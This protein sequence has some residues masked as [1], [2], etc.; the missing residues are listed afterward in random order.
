MIWR[1]FRGGIKPKEFKEATAT[2]PIVT[3]PLPPRVILP[4]Q[5]HLGERANPVVVRD[6][7]V[8][9][10]QII[11][12]SAAFISAPV[13]ASISGTVTRVTAEVIEIARRNREG[14]RELSTGKWENLDK[15]PA[16]AI[17]CIARK[18]GIV[19]LGGATFPTAVKL[20]PPAGCWV[21]TLIINGCECEPYLTA[22][23]R[24]MVEQS[25]EIV[26]GAYA[27]AQAL[28]AVRIIFAVE[29]NKPD[30]AKKLAEALTAAQ[31]RPYG[32]IIRN[33]T[34]EVR[35]VPSRYPQG[36]E[37]QLI[38]SLTGRVVPL[39]GLP[40]QVGVLVHNVATA[41]ALAEAIRKA[42]PLI[43]RVVTVTGPI[44]NAPGNYLVRLGTPIRELL[45][46][47][48]G[49]KEP[50]KAIILGG[51]MMGEAQVDDG[52]PVTKG[53]SGVLVF[54]EADLA[55]VRQTR[56]IRCARCVEVCP[57][58]LE[59]LY[60]A[61]LAEKELWSE[62]IQAGA[63]YCLECGSCAYICPA[64]RP[65]AELIRRAKVKCQEG[66][67]VDER[68]AGSQSRTASA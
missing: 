38:W 43:E 42:K 60:L 25:A 8:E 24:L 48:G 61:R 66:G 13:H 27:M 17:R 23:H 35:L 44:V 12:N 4:L 3:V 15:L 53:T 1:P 57:M 32:A 18:A 9:A 37:K 2:K 51:P 30:A 62:A 10:G 14:V 46:Y 58:G 68:Q 39:G 55:P 64:K 31:L 52:A 67:I 65:V 45:A 59:P 11:G 34:A 19:G 54:G 20:T 36:A 49:V 47:A 40:A 41:Y 28:Q 6:E 26:F 33:T 5:Q 63:A 29:D 56:C 7:L 16:D 21:N 50:V 22:D